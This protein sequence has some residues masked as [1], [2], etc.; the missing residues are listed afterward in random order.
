MGACAHVEVRGQLVGLSP[1]LPPDVA[2]PLLKT[3]FLIVWN[4]SNSLHVCLK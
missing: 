4:L 1:L 3:K 2:T